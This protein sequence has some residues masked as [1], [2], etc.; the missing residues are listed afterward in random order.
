MVQMSRGLETVAER[1]GD[2]WVINGAKK[3]D[4][5]CACV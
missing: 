2:E 4:W 3:M 5:W 1:H